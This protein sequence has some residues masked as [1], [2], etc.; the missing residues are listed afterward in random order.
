MLNRLN[1]LGNYRLRLMVVFT[2]CLA[3][4]QGIIFDTTA[5]AA[6]ES[7]TYASSGKVIVGSGGLFHTPGK[8]GKTFGSSFQGGG[9]ITDR[10]GAACRVSLTIRT[11]SA[12]E[13]IL[14]AFPGPPSMSYEGDT[15]ALPSCDKDYVSSLSEFQNAR[16]SI[17]GSISDPSPPS[18]ITP[19]PSP[20][21]QQ[22]VVTV[23]SPKPTNQ[24]PSMQVA[25]SGPSNETKAISSWNNG[26]SVSATRFDNVSPGTYKVCVTPGGI[27]GYE[28]CQSVT[29]VA[30]TTANIAFGSAATAYN[31][32][33]KVVKVTVNVD[34]AEFTGKKTYGPADL[35]LVNSA[36][37]SVQE[38]IQ[39]NTNEKG[40]DTGKTPAQTIKLFA[41]INDVE[42]G[43]YR[44]C[45][46]GTQLCSR[47]FA[48]E[49]NQTA[50]AVIHVPV[51]QSESLVAK[52]EQS[53]SCKVEGV[54]WIVCPI[55]NFLANITDGLFGVL[56]LLLAVKPLTGDS[57]AKPVWSIMRNIANVMFVI[58][59]IIIIYS[60]L[61][62]TGIN[63]YGIKKMLPRLIAAAV[64]VNISYWICALAVDASNI[65]GVTLR[66]LLV[67]LLPDVAHYDL[68]VFA[69]ITGWLL[70]GGA[71]A[72]TIGG[73]ILSV[74][75][76][77]GWLA[78]LALL[79]PVLV[80]ALFAVITVVLVLAARQALI[81]ILIVIS[82]LAFVAFLLP[83]TEDWFT[84]WRKLFTVM[85][86]LF[87]IISIIFGG[88]QLAAAI[89]RSTTDNPLI[90]ILSLA[91]QI[92]PLFLTPIVMKFSG[93]VL[94]RFGGIVNNPNKGPFDRLRKG[95]QS[96]GDMQRNRGQAAQLER[97]KTTGRGGAITRWQMRRKAAQGGVENV[98][99]R[100]EA[101]YVAKQIKD[102]DTFRNTVA[103]GTAVSPAS[104]TAQQSA[105]AGA[106]SALEKVRGEE[107]SAAKILIEDARLDAGQRQALAL[108]GSVTTP[109]GKVY[110]G[111]SMQKAA[112]E[113]QMTKG[114][115]KEKLAIVERSGTEEMK[116]FSQTIA[117]GARSMA[118]QNPGLSG[119]TLG[120][121]ED[122]KI[123][124][125]QD[126]QNAMLSALNEG[127]Y[128]A[129]SIADMHDD[130]RELLINIAAHSPNPTHHVAL[131]AAVEKIYSTPEL[132]AKVAGNERAIQQLEQLKNSGQI[133]GQGTFDIPRT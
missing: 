19:R 114:S 130:A 4:L 26:A 109:D 31:E 21:A 23:Y 91:I 118:A 3:L 92:V 38:G 79:L 2:L 54:G 8:L 62:G 17:G 67:G 9:V 40:E 43:S 7:Y 57:A 47:L 119:K 70:A 42:P 32:N 116:A 46:S 72:L 107:V 73:T 28:Q 95:A 75:A 89:V 99:K 58:G 101:G 59:F 98:L 133:P 69:S 96:V 113:E 71:T 15:S 112:I 74:S 14:Q 24:L 76:A 53:T 108:T 20:T 52:D 78:A 48:K 34:I 122:G 65:L 45:I 37:D 126:I 60:Q 87:P 39:T 82:P 132:S 16:I 64:L 83:N 120:M 80:T 97:Y 63:N 102:D 10:T 35:T 103:G 125:N 110:S 49:V 5:N 68:D 84:K 81:I 61:T 85:L 100:A 56:E 93:G 36:G 86:L 25:I 18:G 128:T 11:T 33:G 121:I 41:T 123:T 13:G 90:Y 115:Y 131:S 111:E 127:K 30:N 117:A 66:Q 27:L 12:T 55:S 88:S 105:L 1:L 50:E 94:N 29:K 104:A 124:S 44:V 6:G 22:I 106:V 77:G 129:S 51:D